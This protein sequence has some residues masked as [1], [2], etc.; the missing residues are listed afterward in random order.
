MAARKGRFRAQ[1]SAK[2]SG[3]GKRANPAQYE[4]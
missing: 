4:P 1:V 2:A 3:D